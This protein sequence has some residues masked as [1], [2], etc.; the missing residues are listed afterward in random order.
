MKNFKV[1]SSKKSKNWNYNNPEL[2]AS[3][4]HRFHSYTSLNKV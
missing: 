1:I 2:T 3:L 4:S